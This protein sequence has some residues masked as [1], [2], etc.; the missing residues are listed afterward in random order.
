MSILRIGSTVFFI[1][2]SG[3]RAAL[4]V[5]ETDDPLVKLEWAEEL[6]NLQDR[7]QPA[8]K[9]IREAI[10]LCE[11]KKDDE[12]MGEAYLNYGFFFRSP[13][14]RDKESF[15]RDNGFYDKT[16]TF[17]NRLV[18]SKENFEHAISYYKKTDDYAALTQAYL[19]LG[20]AYHFLSTSDSGNKLNGKTISPALSAQCEPYS[21]SL[22]Y[23]LK[24]LQKKPGA[25]ISLPEGVSSYR[26][27]IEIHL[28][29][30][31]CL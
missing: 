15:Y 3:C 31:G 12:C 29:R 9:L 7:P 28:Q 23:N 2:L 22:Q 4:E 24:H 18:K 30:A 8:E 11:Q 17:D 20:F 5:P 14:V 13:S 27:Y 16:A 25:K 1:V 21:K 6:Y 10:V 19:N 26:E